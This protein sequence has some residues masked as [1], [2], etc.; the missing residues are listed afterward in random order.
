M[1]SHADPRPGRLL[2]LLILPLIFTIAVLTAGQSSAADFTDDFDDNSTNTNIWGPDIF[3]IYDIGRLK[4]KNQRLEYAISTAN[5]DDFILRPLYGGVGPYNVDWET[6]IDLYNGTNPGNKKYSSFGLSITRCGKP[7]HELYA[8]LYAFGGN[9]DQGYPLAKG[10]Y[11][12]LFTDN[13]FNGDADTFD[14]GGG[15]PLTGAVRITFNSLTKVFAAYY[16]TGGGWS[17]LGTFGVAGFAGTN[18]TG[19]WGMDDTKDFCIGLYGYS[20][21]LTVASG[22][23]YGDSFSSSGLTPDKVILVQPTGGEVVTPGPTPYPIQWIA[24]P[25]A[26]TFKLQLSVDNG[27]TWSLIAPDRV[28]GTSYDWTVI[29]PTKNKKQCLVKVSAYDGSN[30][31]IGSDKSDSVFAIEVVKLTSP[32]GGEPLVSGGTHTITWTNH[33]PMAD[34]VILSYTL[35]NGSTWYPIDMGLDQSDDGIFDWVVPAVSKPK[36][37]CLVKVV[38]KDASGNKL[39]SDASD[40]FFT[41]DPPPVP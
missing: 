25:N 37:K 12:A 27:V 26:Q 15:S 34:Q 28:P 21:R 41:I 3:T 35:N 36:E 29:P 17:L 24:P 38:L 18:G 30:V 31:K 22:A 39:G 23:V 14:L 40:E 16:D 19:N 10:F 8:E 33:G 32:N 6:Q 1:R 5:Q 13:T 20:D 2:S 7:K 4:E 9:I 11:A